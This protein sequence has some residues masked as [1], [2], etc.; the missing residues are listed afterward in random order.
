MI[1]SSSL[2][3]FVYN[4]GALILTTTA[5]SYQLQKLLLQLRYR[6][7]AGAWKGLFRGDLPVVARSPLNKPHAHNIAFLIGNVIKYRVVVNK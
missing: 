1:Q 5:R 3:Y 7:Q 4:S 6:S 2:P